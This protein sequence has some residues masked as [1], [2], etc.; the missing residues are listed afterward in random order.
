MVQRDSRRRGAERLGSHLR[1]LRHKKGWTQA[2]AGEAIGVDAVTIRRWELGLFSPST[3]RIEQVADAY[4][5]EVSELIDA[6]EAEEPDRSTAAFP[7]KG[8]V[9][10]GTT[11]VSGTS[12]LGTISLPLQIVQ[13]HPDDYCL[14]VMGDSLVPDGIHDGDVLLVCPERVPNMGSLCVVDMDSSLRAVIL[15]TQR[16]FRARTATGATVDVEI[17]PEQLVGTVAWHVR[18]M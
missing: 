12:D 1:T 5:V 2:L 17:T 10:P 6:A 8:F 11:L 14:R 3:N 13:A 15:I 18:K 7:V 4:G 9:G 16:I